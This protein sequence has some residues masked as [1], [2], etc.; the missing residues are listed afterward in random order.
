MVLDVVVGEVVPIADPPRCAPG[1][2]V[3]DHIGV[4]LLGLGHQPPL[5]AWRKMEEGVGVC[6]W[7][8]VGAGGCVRGVNG[9]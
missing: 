6:G 4:P 2:G 8:G 7:G 1:E 3:G 9:A 5:V